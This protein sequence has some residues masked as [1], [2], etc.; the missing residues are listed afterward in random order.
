MIKKNIPNLLTMGNLFCGLVGLIRAFEG[1]Y[2]YA[3]YWV[4]LGIVFDFFDGMA[5]RALK[6]SSKLGLELDS[7]SDV[8]TSGVVPGV[9]MY[10]VMSQTTSS[11]ILP[12]AG[13]IITLASAFRLGRFNLDTRQSS[14]FIGLPTPA[15]CLFIC[16][17]AVVFVVYSP[18]FLNN[19]WVL[20]SISALSAYV[21]NS[22]IPL[23]ALKF[24]TLDIGENLQKIVFLS[25]SAVLFIFLQIPSIPLIIIFYIL[26]S[27]AW[28]LFQRK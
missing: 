27:L 21:M 22:E 19:Y 28:P 13:F 17:L 6:V 9:V 8:V 10:K 16:S 15:N 5:A 12:Y 7:L 4:F 24:K 18:D 14:S 1:D 2:E 11:D 23:F 26:L 3:L 25:I 20:L